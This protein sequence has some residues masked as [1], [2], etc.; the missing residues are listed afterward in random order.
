MKE[1]RKKIYLVDGSSYIHRAYHA[2]KNLSNSKGFP[3]NAVFGFTNML[4]KLCSEKAPEYLA[5]V[6]DAR[7]PTFRHKIY[8]PYKANRPPV[9][10]ELRVQIPVIKRVLQAMN[11]KVIEKE[12]FE[13][14]DV[15]GTLARLCESQGFDVVM[16]TG[17]KDFRQLVTPAASMLDTMKNATTDYTTLKQV[18]ELEPVKI[19]DVMA[20][21]GDASDNV[22]GVP[23][24]GEKTALGLIRTFGS[25]E[26]LYDGLERVKQK[27]LR[28]N[29]QRFKDDAFLSRDLVRIHRFVPMEEER[30]ECLRVGEPHREALDA[31]FQDLE[32]RSL[33]E[34]FAHKGPS[35]GE[36]QN[37]P[38]MPA[39]SGRD[40]QT[41][42]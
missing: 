11:L 2:I 28:E 35:R 3:T 23:G 20:L 5:V 13:A 32:F 21:S 40:T 34:R 8:E 6:L 12:G 30:I 31:L 9:A 39:D 19:V 42:H 26:A 18:Y 41:N 36:E 22:P 17:D 16:V 7:G 37:Q 25:L 33:R 1:N 27:R 14:D 4:L 15:I 29:L 24:V 38:C 10:E